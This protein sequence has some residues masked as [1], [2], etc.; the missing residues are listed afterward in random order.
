ML[1][2]AAKPQDNNIEQGTARSTC[3]LVSAGL[4]IL[5]LVVYSGC[6]WIT[7]RRGSVGTF[8]FEWEREI[9]FVPFF[10]APYMSIDLFFIA[11]PFLCRSNEELRTFSRRVIAAIVIAGICFLVVPLRFAFPRPHADGV[12]GVIFDWFRGM[13]APYNLFPSLHAALMLLLIDLYR[14]H[15]RG[16]LRAAVTIWF[17]LIALSPL[18]TY[19]HHLIDILGGLAL[20]AGCFYFIR[21]HFSSL[22]KSPDPNNRPSLS[23][24]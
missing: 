4:S 5:F 1:K 23:R 21:V 13:D 7:A 10:I 24:L 9:P 17:A 22:P 15:T 18:L 14:R 3:V 6:N 20:A 19:Q 11:A 16:F 12:L 2:M 8:Y